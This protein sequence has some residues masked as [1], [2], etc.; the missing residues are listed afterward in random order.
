MFSYNTSVHEATKFTPYEL[1]FG[2]RARISSSMLNPE[3]EDDTYDDY[4][5]ALSNKLAALHK[6]TEENMIKAKIRSK[7]YF[8]KNIK[9]QEINTKDYVNV[10]KSAKSCSFDD[11]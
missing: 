7:R 8:D 11:V 6:I 10:T 1:L 3:L 4:V 2:R 9:E 5:T